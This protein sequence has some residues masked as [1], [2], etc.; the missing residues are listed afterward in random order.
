MIWTTKTRTR[1][2]T[3]LRT[4][5]ITARIR[6]RTAL[7]TARIAKINING[8]L[9]AAEKFSPPFFVSYPRAVEYFIIEKVDNG[10]VYVFDYFNE[11]AGGISGTE[12]GS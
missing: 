11:A 10:G 1:V 7:K 8:R 5:T 4:V 9:T 2:R 6:A 3:A 12:T